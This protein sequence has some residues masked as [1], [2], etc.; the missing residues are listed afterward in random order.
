MRG[1]KLVVQIGFLYVLYRIGVFIQEVFYIPVPGS[2][3]GMMLLLL[4]LMMGAVKVKYLNDGAH[5]LLLY[6]P[7]FF[8]P[9][10]VGV[11]NH[12]GFLSSRD[13]LIMLIALLIGTILVLVGSGLIAQKTATV[14]DNKTKVTRGDGK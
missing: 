6:L 11:M 2:I 14:V 4:F 7:L 12:F 3:I 5:I 10:T 1:M 9:A 13:G 8:V